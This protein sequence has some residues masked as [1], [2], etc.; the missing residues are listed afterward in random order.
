[1]LRRPQ[2]FLLASK[3][4]ARENGQK[5]GTT[6]NGDGA[7]LRY[8]KN[9]KEIVRKLGTEPDYGLRSQVGCS[10]RTFKAD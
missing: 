10:V 1:M 5:M 3:F 6:E 8:A 2:G 4:A 7:R 9:L